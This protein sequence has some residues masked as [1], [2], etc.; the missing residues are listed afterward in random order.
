M[1]RLL[2]WLI[3]FSWSFCFAWDK[4]M[5]LRRK[6]GARD[7]DEW[8]VWYHQFCLP[9]NS[10]DPDSLSGKSLSEHLGESCS[11]PGYAGAVPMTAP[12]RGTA[13]VL[14]G[15]L[16]AVLDAL[17]FRIF[18][19]NG[20]SAYLGCNRAFAADAG[21]ESPRAIVGKYDHEMFWADQAD[22]YRADDRLVMT[23]GRSRID[24]ET[25]RPTP[26]GRKIWVRITKVPL[27]DDE[28]CV[29]GL[30]GAYENITDRKKAEEESLRTEK[31]ESLQIL[32]G[33]L[34]NDFNNL[35]T[36][37]LGGL[38]LALMDDKLP[39]STYRILK[40]AERACVGSKRLT[41]L[42]MSSASS[43]PQFKRPESISEIL[44]DAVNLGLADSS[45]RCEMHVDQDL[46]QVHCNA[47]QTRRALTNVI[48]NA[49]EAMQHGG[50][51]K[52]TAR[53]VQF[54]EGELPPLREGRHVRVSVQ[55]SGIGIPEDHLPKIFDPYF[56][57]KE[58]GSKKGIG[59]G[60]TVTYAII[61]RQE[62]HVRVE[63][64]AGV[65][66]VIHLYLPAC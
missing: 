16:Q 61:K 65:G 59:L 42:L 57:T 34:A 45:L 66:S 24:A 14:Q 13:A 50:A 60:L 48:V 53:N 17:P 54:G 23:S 4:S 6:S 26:D 9:G 55:D 35:M 49:R 15:D 58:R 28:G 47:K 63:S 41:E 8:A 27:F 3:G 19:K 38:S 18:W 21:M 43:A 64:Q 30:L 51:I 32:A 10:V 20:H 2:L 29:I 25:I 52:I 44:Q 7:G 46:W 39:A 1:D 36:V 62:G 56:S 37:I 31:L 22:R 11:L 12:C 40:E 33:G 5:D